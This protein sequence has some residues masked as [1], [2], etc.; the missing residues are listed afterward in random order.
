[1]LCPQNTRTPCKLGLNVFKLHSRHSESN[2]PSQGNIMLPVQAAQT[3]DV[4]VC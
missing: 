2:L 1:M 4:N 3:R